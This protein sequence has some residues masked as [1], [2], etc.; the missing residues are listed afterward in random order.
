[1]WHQW[2]TKA[3]ING[4]SQKGRETRREVIFGEID[5]KDGSFDG[6]DL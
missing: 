5:G 6:G 4:V 1:M 3:E 2:P